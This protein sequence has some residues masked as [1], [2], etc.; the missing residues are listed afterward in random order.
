MKTTLLCAMTL[1]W[2]R[3]SLSLPASILS[4]HQSLLNSLLQEGF[5]DLLPAPARASKAQGD[6]RALITMAGP[7]MCLLS[8]SLEVQLCFPSES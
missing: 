5:L 2:R 1:L 4:V 7:R 6:H 8:H 3:L